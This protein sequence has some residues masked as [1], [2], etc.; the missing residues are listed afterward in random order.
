MKDLN[1]IL[2]GNILVQTRNNILTVRQPDA[3]TR[4]LA[5]FFAEQVYEEAFKQNIYLQ[6]ELEELIIENGWW[7]QD[8]E[9]ELKQIPKDIEPKSLTIEK[10]KE[11][12]EEAPKKKGRAK[13]K[14]KPKGK[15]K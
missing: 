7:T 13:T 11:I 5:D 10:C 6:E 9:D 8:E 12:M 1:K 14:A 2:S 3:G 15:K 4:Y